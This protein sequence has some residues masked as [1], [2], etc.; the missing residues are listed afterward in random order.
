[1]RTRLAGLNVL[2]PYGLFRKHAQEIRIAATPKGTQKMKKSSTAKRIVL[3][4][5]MVAFSSMAFAA[6]SHFAVDALVS[7]SAS[8]SSETLA[9]VL[10]VVGL[11]G[12]IARRRNGRLG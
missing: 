5:G 10:A 1:M 8:G 4:V 7:G 3:S 2:S 12:T 9:L 11:M 6:T